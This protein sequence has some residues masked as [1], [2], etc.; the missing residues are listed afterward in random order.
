VSKR[1]REFEINKGRK[2][3]AENGIKQWREE[4]C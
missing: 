1:G 3:A 2:Q 4:R